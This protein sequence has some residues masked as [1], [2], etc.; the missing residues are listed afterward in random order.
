MA[1]RPRCRDWTALITQ[2]L[3]L[4]NLIQISGHEIECAPKAAVYYTLHPTPMSAPCYTSAPSSTPLN[5]IWPEICCAEFLTSTALSVCIRVWQHDRSAAAAAVATDD[6]DVQHRRQQPPDD[7]LLFL[8]VVSFSGLVPISKRTDVKLLP[9]SLVFHLHGGFFTSAACLKAV[10]VLEQLA[11]VV[12]QKQRLV[13][14]EEAIKVGL[15]AA[16]AA[17]ADCDDGN[18]GNGTSSAAP[19]PAADRLHE[20][21][22]LRYIERKFYA[23]EVR[24]SYTVDK[25]QLLQR[26]QRQ[27][28]KNTADTEALR[29]EICSRSAYCM[30]QPADVAPGT[31]RLAAGSSGAAPATPLTLSRLLNAQPAAP[32]PEV[33]WRGQQVRRALETA[34]LRCELLRS[35][36]TEAM[37]RTAELQRKLVQL[38]DANIERE[39][40]LLLNYHELQREHERFVELHDTVDRQTGQLRRMRESVQ[41]RQHQ[42]LRELGEVFSIERVPVS[43]ATAAQVADG[44]RVYAINGARLPNSEE[45]GEQTSASE[46]S[47]ALGWAAHLTVLCSVVLD[48]PLRNAVVLQGPTVRIRDDVKEMPDGDREYD[49]CRRCSAKVTTCLPRM[50]LFTFSCAGFRCTVAVVRHR[51]PCAMPVFCSTRTS[52]NCSSGW[53]TRRST[54]ARRWPICCC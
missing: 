44:E 7:K 33:L 40:W 14:A 8:W 20:N 27:L 9:N 54:A 37:V 50:F 35:Q 26:K 49:D 29:A 17:A 53:A 2:Q 3:R 10:S 39:S 51:W 43:T 47:V 31:A 25:L 52:G 15:A 6:G 34:R 30:T 36:R 11:F 42:L 13:H 21:L 22:K 28:K 1:S 24:A 23:T 19:P 38:N 5:A 4:R 45:F 41:L 12:G 32:R 48:V 46:M 16:A 18:D